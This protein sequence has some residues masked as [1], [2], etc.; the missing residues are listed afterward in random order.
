MSDKI[1]LPVEFIN[2]YQKLLGN[3]AQQFFK[4]I[5]TGET[6]KAFRLNPLKCD[7]K[8]VS[9]NLSKPVS[10]QANAYLGQVDGKGIDWVSGYAYSQEPSAMFPARALAVKPGETVLD[11][12]AAPGG[13]STAL[14]ADLKETGL[15]VANE[16]STSRSKNLRENIE[17]WGASNCLV[18]NEDSFRLAE[19][20][21]QFFDAILVDAPCS[22]EGMFRKNSDAITYWSQDYVLECRKRQEE[23]L[24]NAVKMLKPGGRLLYSTCT[25][26]P[27][28]DEGI[29]E[30]LITK[31]D[32]Q[33]I[34]ITSFKEGSKGRNEWANGIDVTA[35]RRFWPQTGIGEG[36]F[37]ALFEKPN[38]QVSLPNKA[39][40]KKSKRKNQTKELFTKAERELVIDFLN[41]FKLPESVQNNL[42]KL[43]K[44][45]NHVFIPVIEDTAGI[46]VVNN[47][48]ELGLLKKNRFEPSHQLALV[49]AQ[50]L[51]DKVINLKTADEFKSYLHGETI[52]S[53]ENLSGFVLISYQG[54]IFS[55]GKKTK[56]T[57]KNFYPKGLRI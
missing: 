13:K 25:Y 50:V 3:Q 31:E 24:H 37:M 49:L 6:Q 29:C 48:L 1:S 54:K 30:Y 7:F 11:L 34:P 23:I 21:P 57:V 28:E 5:E 44:S 35:S 8:N 10:G 38:T 9:L 4:A 47:G 15:L 56:Q 40:K 2:K 39:K 16:I 32:L 41:D 27:E 55:F 52:T 12:C 51:Q 53:A 20:F 14:L 18:T 33:I 43:S 46:K 19:K 42:D 45:K 36:Q 26:A 22:G 17:R